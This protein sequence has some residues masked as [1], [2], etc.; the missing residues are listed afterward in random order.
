MKTISATCSFRQTSIFPICELGVVSQALAAFW[1]QK[2]EREPGVL[3]TQPLCPGQEGLC[4]LRSAQSSLAYLQCFAAPFQVSSWP[5]SG[6]GWSRGLSRLGGEFC[7]AI[8]PF[9]HRRLKVPQHKCH[10]FL[11]KSVATKGSVHLPAVWSVPVAIPGLADFPWPMLMSYWKAS[12]DVCS[13]DG[14]CSHWGS[15][16]SVCHRLQIFP[17]F[18]LGQVDSHCGNFLTPIWDQDTDLELCKARAG[19]LPSRTRSSSSLCQCVVAR[20]RSPAPAVEIEFLSE[21]RH[22]PRSNSLSRLNI[23][24]NEPKVS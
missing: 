6:S 17:T 14:L 15:C 21:H 18:S 22:S 13:Q 19:P 7:E 1:A 9:H 3:S 24:D 4:G 5:G 8:Y 12:L 11:W 20:G 10:E 16:V 23:S 2:Q